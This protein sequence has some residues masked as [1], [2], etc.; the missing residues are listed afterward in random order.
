MLI[1]GVTFLHNSESSDFVWTGN[2]QPSPPYSTD[3]APL[4]FHLFV[5][6][7]EFWGWETS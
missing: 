7:K 2:H 5:G 4:D 3:L 6:F 1:S